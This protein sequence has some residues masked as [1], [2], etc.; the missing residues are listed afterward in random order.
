MMIKNSIKLLCANFTDVWKLL[1]YLILS[2]GFCV[3]LLAIFYPDFITY[4][5]L[6]HDKAS[7]A[8]VFQSGTLYGGAGIASALTA[9]ANATKPN[10]PPKAN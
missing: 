6:A 4:A 7:L 1:V 5:T 2:I 9:I 8:S 3:G 10:H